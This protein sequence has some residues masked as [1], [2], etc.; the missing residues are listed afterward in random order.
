MCTLARV[1]YTRT[2]VNRL[3]CL[4]RAV[5]LSTGCIRLRLG[6]P[7][8]DRLLALLLRCFCM[9]ASTGCGLGVVV[10]STSFRPVFTCTGTAAVSFC[11]VSCDFCLKHCCGRLIREKG[12]SIASI[13]GETRDRV[14]LVLC[15]GL[16]LEQVGF[17]VALL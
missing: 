1:E 5:L 7:G 15:R 2:A 9:I 12:T 10:L 4:L 6:A 11:S 8:M 14:A 13:N 16:N 17:R 3:P